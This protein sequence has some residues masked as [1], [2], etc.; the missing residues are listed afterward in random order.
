MAFGI[1]STKNTNE[2]ESTKVSIICLEGKSVKMFFLENES[3]GMKYESVL[4]QLTN[5]QLQS[6]VHL[7]RDE[8]E[9]FGYEFNFNDLQ[10]YSLPNS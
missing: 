9:M 3:V 4:S 7:K 8:M 2:L 6:L 10:S 5:D 1:L